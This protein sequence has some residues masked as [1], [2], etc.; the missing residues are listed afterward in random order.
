MVEK[1]PILLPLEKTRNIYSSP[2]PWWAKIKAI[3]EDSPAHEGP[4]RGAIDIIVPLG[5]PVLAPLGGRVVE[6][7]DCHERYGPSSEFLHDLNYIT[8]S[9]GKGEY[10]QLAH[11]AKGSVRVK[12]GDR[13]KKG[14]RLATTGNSGWMTEPHLHF[15]VFRQ[16]SNRGG[17]KGLE[18]ALKGR[19]KSR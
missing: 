17:F 8:L 19:L 1:E 16:T 5:T 12:L 3:E 4:Y 10:S 13:V 2:V 15:L 6:I 18:I 14:R 7:I 9:H 11:L